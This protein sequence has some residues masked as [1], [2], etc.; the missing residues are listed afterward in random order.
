MKTLL[1]ALA[2]A[3]PLTASAQEDTLFFPAALPCTP[4]SPKLYDNFK[5]SNGEIPMLK[6]DVVL[7]SFKDGSDQHLRMEMFMNPESKEFSILVFFKDDE[8]ACVLTV[9]K[10][11]SPIFTGTPL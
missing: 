9:G 11:L 2:L 8:I 5:E 1:L 6:G 7:Q 10:N 3:A 4:P